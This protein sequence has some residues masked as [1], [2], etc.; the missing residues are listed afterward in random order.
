[1][2]GANYL[3][4]A[5]IRYHAG[6]S[7][8]L[9]LIFAILGAIP[10]MSE[11]LATLAE[12]QL[13]E[14]ANAT[15]L[16]YGPP[17]SQLDL[18]LSALFFEGEPLAELSMNDFETLAD[19][20][21]GTPLP[22]LRT[23][24]ARGFPIVGIDIEY[25]EFRQL[26]IAEGRPMVRL[27]EAVLGADVAAR[28]GLGPGDNIQSEIREIFEL[29]GAYPL[30]MTVT[31]VLDRVGTP[32]DTAI[33]TGLRTAWVV[34]GFGH[35]HEN[36]ATTEDESVVLSRDE[37]RIIA[38]AKLTE[39]IEITEEN[40]SSFHSHGD[41]D[42]FPLSAILIDPNDKRGAAILRGRIEDAGSARQVF[43]P[44]G[45]VQALLDEVFRIKSVLSMLVA[46]VSFAA[47]MALGMMIWLSLKL[48]RREFEISYLI[49]ADRGAMVRLI[50]AELALLISASAVL[51]VALLILIEIF[52]ADLVRALLFGG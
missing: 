19:M 12:A 34:A 3:A 17:G 1:M 38:N 27:G 24:S 35:G 41:P 16:I 47:L 43:R 32:D 15:P 37:G 13:L 50:G 33:F 14:R 44:L 18:T 22:I 51:C 46:A 8:L 9:V 36:L 52:G 5:H 7:T 29:A 28:S 2:I 49:G 45:V 39:Y 26:R 11:R 6:R 42:E 25:L 10:L 20:G 23:H 4:W 48:R 30:R 40:A 31:G 21:L